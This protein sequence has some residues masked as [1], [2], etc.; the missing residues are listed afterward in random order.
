VFPTSQAEPALFALRE[1]WKDKEQLLALGPLLLELS[2]DGLLSAEIEFQL[3]L[4]RFYITLG[5]VARSCGQSQPSLAYFE[6]PKSIFEH[7]AQAE[8]NRTDLQRALAVSY[9]RFG[10]LE[11]PRSNRDGPLAFS[12]IFRH[13]RTSR[14]G[15]TQPR[16]PP[17]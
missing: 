17:T 12:K 8:P 1:E 3:E 4:A 14:P 10:D 11:R 15:L 9:G 5:D 16:R 13:R 7:L 6:R 2:H